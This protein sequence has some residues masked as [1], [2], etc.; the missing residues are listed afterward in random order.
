MA[1]EPDGG[2]SAK[3]PST[4]TSLPWIAAQAGELRKAT[5][6]ARSS[7][8]THWLWSSPGRWERLLGVSRIEVVMTL[9]CTPRS[10]TSRENARAH[11]VSPA[12]DAAYGPI[13]GIG[14]RPRSDVRYTNHPG[15]SSC[16]RTAREASA[17][18]STLAAKSSV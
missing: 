2:D 11:A 3:V 14:S 9:T 6:S 13:D 10:R 16:R 7:R 1:T 8:R 18:D 15:P 17:A 4:S 5:T 12:L